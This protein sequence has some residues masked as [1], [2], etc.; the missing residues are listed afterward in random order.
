M[1]TGHAAPASSDPAMAFKDN[2][3]DVARLRRQ[4][5][6]TPGLVDVSDQGLQELL[7]ASIAYVEDMVGGGFNGAATTE[8]RDGNG[9]SSM[10]L[11][12]R[13]ATSVSLIEVDL[14][15]LGLRRTYTAA[16]VKLYPL[17]G[18]VE[19]FT[20]KLAAEQAT[21]YLDQQ[22]NGN[23]FPTLP[24]CVRIVYTYGFPQYDPVAAA[25]SFDG[26]ATSQPGNLIDP[27]LTRRLTQVQQAAVCDAAASYLAQVAALGVGTVTSVSFDGFSQALNPQAYG[28]QVQALVERRDALL[29]RNKRK[30][31]LSS[32]G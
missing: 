10:T 2:R 1:G 19:I 30:F 15:V 6:G 21:L 8:L 14:P 31:I 24:Q 28:P 27:T 29:E 16:E 26:G 17:P 7:D 23:I 12:H 22:V 4:L 25:T 13:P 11:M 5:T 32:T 9:T 18:R 3:P 20:F